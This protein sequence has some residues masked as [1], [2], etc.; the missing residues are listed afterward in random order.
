MGTYKSYIAG[1]VFSLLLTFAAFG[2]VWAHI[3]QGQLST[4]L[5]IAVLL[6][7]A[8]AQLM[9]QLLFFLHVGSETRPRW[10]MLA[11]LFAGLVLVIIVG[12]SLWIMKNLDYNMN[13]AAT[14]DFIIKDEGITNH[15]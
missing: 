13:P 12:G 11:L 7:L 2:A 4:P 14:T 6:V 10:N 5:L 1:F 8:A 3:N 9:V 15:R